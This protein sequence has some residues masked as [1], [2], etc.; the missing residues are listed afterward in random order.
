M[1]MANVKGTDGAAAQGTQAGTAQH[2]QWRIDAA[3]SRAEFTI[4]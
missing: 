3:A 2:T 1:S 4:H